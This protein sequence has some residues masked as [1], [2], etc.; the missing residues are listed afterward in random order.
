MNSEIK[1]LLGYN[2]RRI[3]KLNNL[4][5]LQLAE[6]VD[7]AFTFISDIENGKKWVSPETLEKLSQ[8][9][10]I[11]VYQFF[12]PRDYNFSENK[13]IESFSQEILEAIKRIESRYL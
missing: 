12:L 1:E 9:M 4:S 7:M 5:Q 3:R 10:D 2:L 13:T 11:E 8:A 6:Q